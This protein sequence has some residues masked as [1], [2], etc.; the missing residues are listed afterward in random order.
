MNF[1]NNKTILITGG[2]GSFGNAAVEFLTSKCR[3]KKIII[4]SRDENKQ[5]EM[6]K[7]FKNKNLRFFLGDVRDEE[8]LIMALKEVDYVIHA[9]AQKQVPAA[10]Y[11]P[12][13]CIKTNVYGA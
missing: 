2:T 11:N 12:F 1:L 9:A 13:E 6:R 4:F 3:L 7:K 8:R 10:E 5:F